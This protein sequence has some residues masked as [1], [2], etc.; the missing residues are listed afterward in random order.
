[1]YEDDD[2]WP[3]KCPACGEEFLKKVGWLKTHRSIKCPGSGCPTTIEASPEE[4][5][6]AL[7]KAKQGMFDPYREMMRLNKNSS[8]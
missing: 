5:S 7:I 8:Q 6:R 2:F 1:M 4:F 3:I